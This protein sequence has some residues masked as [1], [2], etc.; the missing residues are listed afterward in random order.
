LI[1]KTIFSQLLAKEKDALGYQTL[2]FENLDNK[3]FGERY[4]MLVVFPNWEDKI[5]E[6]HDIGYLTYRFVEEGKDSWYD[7]ENKKFIPYNYT[8]F[9]YMKFVKKEDNNINN[10]IIL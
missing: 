5:P 3:N 7:N 10:N 4:I 6:L 2:V 1:N 9:I 8:N